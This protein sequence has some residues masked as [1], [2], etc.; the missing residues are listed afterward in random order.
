[1][2]T[3]KVDPQS[4]APARTFAAGA[5]STETRAATKAYPDRDPKARP[6]LLDLSSFFNA[7]LTD[8]WHGAQ[9]ASGND[10]GSLPAGIQRLDGIEY[11]LRG[12]IQLASKAATA[13]RYPT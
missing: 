10:L 4:L 3:N 11:D 7:R 2:L 6:Q 13:S 8:T 1:M 5:M 9:T 12:V